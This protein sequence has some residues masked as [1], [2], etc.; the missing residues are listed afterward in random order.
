MSEGWGVRTKD[1]GS[2]TPACWLCCTVLPTSSGAA[3]A[4]AEAAPVAVPASVPAPALTLAFVAVAVAVAAAV[5]WA[6]T[7]ALAVRAIVL[8]ARSKAP[9]RTRATPQSPPPRIVLPSR[10]HPAPTSTSRTWASACV[11]SWFARSTALPP[12]TSTPTPPPE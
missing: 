6:S 4:P 5:P 11:C 12:R 3:A 7:P 10:A 2:E 8:R 1:Q 9:Q